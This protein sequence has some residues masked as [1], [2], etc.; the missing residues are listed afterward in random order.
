MRARAG[1]GIETEPA[2]DYQRVSTPGLSS[3]YPLVRRTDAQV[4]PLF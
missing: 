4:L 2:D 1:L 3:R